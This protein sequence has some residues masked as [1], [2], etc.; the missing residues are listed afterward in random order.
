MPT[1]QELTDEN[2]NLKAQAADLQ[3]RNAR[4]LEVEVAVKGIIHQIEV[5]EGTAEDLQDALVVLKTKI[6]LDEVIK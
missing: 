6:A 2:I 4:L 1:I 3:A 5:H